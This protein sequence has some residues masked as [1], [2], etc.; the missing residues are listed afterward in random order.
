M[1]K[2]EGRAHVSPNGPSEVLIFK[3]YFILS[4]L[5]S[6][7]DI[8]QQLTSF[9]LFEVSHIQYLSASVLDVNL[10]KISSV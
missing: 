9:P 7:C 8:T 5:N 4:S 1:W 3:T 6:M 2:A 10:Y